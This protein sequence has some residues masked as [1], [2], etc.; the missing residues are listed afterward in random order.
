VVFAMC[1]LLSAL[2][3]TARV[4]L[5]GIGFTLAWSTVFSGDAPDLADVMN[6]DSGGYKS[7]S[8][9]WVIS[10]PRYAIEVIYFERG[11]SS[12]MSRNSK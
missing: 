8:W 12:T 6:S 2:V 5:I 7:T 10:A 11:P 3:P 9:I 4:A 1:G